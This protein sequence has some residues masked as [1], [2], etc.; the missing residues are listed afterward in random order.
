[1]ILIIFFFLFAQLA[2]GSGDYYV[3]PQKPKDFDWTK[4]GI[5]VLKCLL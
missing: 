3:G 2:L 5:S 1:M 4:V